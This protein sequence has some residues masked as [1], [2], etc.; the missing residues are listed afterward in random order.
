MVTVIIVPHVY[1][2]ND[3]YDRYIGLSVDQPLPS[4]FWGLGYSGYVVG[5]VREACWH[6][7]ITRDLPPGNH[8]VVIGTSA[9]GGGFTQDISVTL[10]NAAGAEVGSHAR[11]GISRYQYMY[12]AFT[13]TQSGAITSITGGTVSPGSAPPV[14]PPPSEGGGG[15]DTGGGG[16][17]GTDFNQIINQMMQTMIPSMMNI[18]L[19]TTM[20]QMMMGMMAGITSG[21]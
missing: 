17:T 16:G 7:N 10:K 9:V 11:D 14:P 4:D 6:A 5:I 21:L 12:V 15:Q 1:R 19:M 20:M 3:A 13:I 18:M 8:Y 2:F